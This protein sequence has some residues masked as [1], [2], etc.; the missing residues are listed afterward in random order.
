[1]QVYIGPKTRVVS[2]HPLAK[3][4]LGREAA[5]LARESLY[6]I[7]CFASDDWDFE[8]GCLVVWALRRMG[9]RRL[10]RLW[11]CMVVF[12]LDRF[13]VCVCL[14]VWVTVCLLLSHFVLVDGLLVRSRVGWFL[15]VGFFLRK[16]RIPLDSTVPCTP[17]SGHDPSNADPWALQ[18]RTPTPQGSSKTTPF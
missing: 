12:V 17:I 11:S 3:R 16:C 14:Y 4:F 5:F 9:W 15:L 18:R 10:S 13:R 7:F 6:N 2:A 1:M 8:V